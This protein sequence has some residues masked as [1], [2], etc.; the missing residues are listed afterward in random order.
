MRSTLCS[1]SA[2]DERAD[3]VAQHAQRGLAHL[4]EGRVVE[5]GPAAIEGQR[6]AGDGLRVVADAFQLRADLHGRIGEA[7][8]AGGGLLPDHELEAEPVQLL[9]QLVDVLVAE[10]DEIRR[11]PLRRDEGVQR[12]RDRALALLRHLAH[13]GADHVHVVLQARFEL[14]RHLH[15]ASIEP[16]ACDSR[17]TN[18]LR[19]REVSR[20]PL[21]ISRVRGRASSNAITG[22]AGSPEAAFSARVVTPNSATSATSAVTQ[23]TQYQSRSQPSHNAARPNEVAA[24]P[25]CAPS[26]YGAAR[27]SMAGELDSIGP[28][29]G[30]RDV[31]AP[32]WARRS[33]AAVVS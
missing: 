4:L 17:A 6:A 25:S 8:V 2:V 14:T 32:S 26:R 23:R 20:R 7:E 18:R 1:T 10:D 33:S 21:I 12:A 24:A 19:H 29:S 9:L 11:L 13:L 22:P 31:R 27:R 3:G 28:D 30:R 16:A 15:R 5:V